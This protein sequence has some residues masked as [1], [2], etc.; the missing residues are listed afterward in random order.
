ML[1]CL[2]DTCNPAGEASA[3]RAQA[4]AA[5]QLQDAAELL[6]DDT[7]RQAVQRTLQDVQT[8]GLSAQ[9][10][11]RRLR[12]VEQARDETARRVLQQQ[13]P[14]NTSDTV[15]SLAAPQLKMVIWVVDMCGKGGGPSTTAEVRPA[16][17]LLLACRSNP[18][19]RWRLYRVVL[20]FS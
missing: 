14:S 4:A 3:S 9:Q 15:A 11:Q 17:H 19:K 13:G 8:H 7:S 12:A 18:V 5:L 1:C 2:S 10:Q 6:Q 20:T 16:L